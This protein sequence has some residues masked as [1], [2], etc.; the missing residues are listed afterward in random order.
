MNW[1]SGYGF[2]RVLPEHNA[3]I[4]DFYFKKRLAHPES[5]SDTHNHNEQCLIAQAFPYSSMGLLH[6][7]VLFSVNSDIRI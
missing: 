7:E 4:G 6:S 3:S 5:D 2:I 1:F